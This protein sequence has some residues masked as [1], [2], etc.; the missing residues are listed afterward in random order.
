MSRLYEDIERGCLENGEPI[1]AKWGTGFWSKQPE[2]EPEIYQRACPI[3]GCEN[4]LFYGFHL[5]NDEHVYCKKCGIDKIG[6]PESE[7]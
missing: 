3:C 7:E 4:S 2:P 1:E 5:D 6:Y